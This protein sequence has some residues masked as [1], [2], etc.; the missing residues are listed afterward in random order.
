MKSLSL[1]DEVS[2]VEEAITWMKK[3]EE[4]FKLPVNSLS[5]YKHKQK[6][7]NKTNKYEDVTPYYSV[8][9]AMRADSVT[10]DDV[11]NGV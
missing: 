6:Y 4:Q 5:I 8:N 3:M 2:S 9:L 11:A 1:T 7:N 10:E